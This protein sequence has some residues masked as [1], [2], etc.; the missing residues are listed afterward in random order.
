M[1]KAMLV[2]ASPEAA[3]IYRAHLKADFA[4]VKV[5]ATLHEASVDKFWGLMESK[6]PDV[7]IM[8]IRFFA[9]S[10][11]RIIGEITSRYPIIKLLI[12]GTYDDYDYLRASME[13]GATDYIYKPIKIRE[14]QLA[15]GHIVDIFDEMRQKAIQDAQMLEG[16]AKDTELFRHRFLTNLTGGILLNED[17][18]ESSMKYF[19][20]TLETPAAAFVIRVDRFKTI[21]A[22]LDERNKHLLIYRIFWITKKFLEDNKLGYTF[23]NSFNSI[24]C[25]IG[26]VEGV[27]SLLDVC[28]NLKEVITKRCGLSVTIGMGRTYNDFASLRFSAKEAEAALRY[29][30]LMG[31]NT[32]IPIDFV[33]PDNHITYRYPAKKE[34]IFIFT[35]VVGE[36]EY[37]LRLLNEI[38]DTIGQSQLPDRLLPKIIMNMVI[39]ISRYASE[40]GMDIESRFRE[41]FNLSE[42][43]N[44][45]TISDAKM[46]MEYGLKAFC[47]FVA[48]QND[49]KS[50]KMVALTRARCEQNFNEDLNLEG[51]ATEFGTTSEFLGKIFQKIL[52]TSFKEY[53]QHIR[54]SKAKEI[55]QGEEELTE[56]EIGRRVGF[57][58]VRVFRSVFRSREGVFPLEFRR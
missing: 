52:G 54:I 30:H 56:E 31:Y 35:A 14:F 12:T 43:L 49:E 29:R 58:D 44:L 25:V 37:A 9:L 15:M 23:I 41:F 17:E 8:D 5:V 38:L 32:I 39:S 3:N 24:I 27:E 10:T 46:F 11:L 55:L 26:G 50:A 2:D 33:E 57:F 7:L 16:Y 22:K 4:A 36:F 20:M 21:M 45:Q 42:I 53:L 18:I 6:K 34:Q 13:Y 51:L 1:L 48:E 40:L 28:H 47:H 19:G